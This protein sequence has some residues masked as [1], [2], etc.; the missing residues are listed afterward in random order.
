MIRRNLFLVCALLVVAMVAASAQGQS[1]QPGGSVICGPNCSQYYNIVADSGFN[2]SS[3]WYFDSPVYRAT[4]GSFCGGWQPAPFAQFP[5]TGQQKSVSQSV[6]AL[7]SNAG[8]GTHFSFQYD[9]EITDPNNNS[10]NALDIRISQPNGFW[11]IVD[12]PPGGSQSCIHRS[13][14]LG[15]HPEW[16]GQNLTIVIFGTVVN[17]N[18]NIKVDNVVMQQGG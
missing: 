3:C 13:I 5:Y 17:S 14:D 7:A 15:N 8:Y 4:S 2:E 12:Q 1:C 10:A 18:A 9:Y 16:A 11:Y 6:T